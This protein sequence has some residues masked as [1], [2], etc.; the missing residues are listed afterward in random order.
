MVPRSPKS[1]DTPGAHLHSW[2]WWFLASIGSFGMEKGSDGS[3]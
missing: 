3:P 2:S 1:G